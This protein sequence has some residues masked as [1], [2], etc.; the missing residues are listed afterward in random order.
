[1]SEQLSADEVRRI[2]K[3]VRRLVDAMDTQFRVPG[4]NW[5]FGID[6]LLGLLP[7]GGDVVSAGISLYI[8]R[9][10]RRLG[11]SDHTTARMILNVVL[12]TVVGTVP[13]VGDLFDAAFKA[14]RRNLELLERELAAYEAAKQRGEV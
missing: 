3:R 10:A 6:P 14:N 11:V 4:T 5:R 13:L 12:D 1:M 8:I 9:E 2:V 7:G